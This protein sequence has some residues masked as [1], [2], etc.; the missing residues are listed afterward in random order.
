MKSCYIVAQRPR[1]IARTWRGGFN[2]REAINTTAYTYIYDTAQSIEEEETI[3]IT[4]GR[5]VYRVN[6]PTVIPNCDV[7]KRRERDTHNVAE[8]ENV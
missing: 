4:S 5:A 7:A 2:V 1:K 6:K 8:R 3:E